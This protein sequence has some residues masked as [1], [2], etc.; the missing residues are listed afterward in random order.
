MKIKNNRIVS[1]TEDELY[2]YW[3]THAWYMIYDFQDYLCRMEDCGVEIV[4]PP[5]LSEGDESGK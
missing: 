5:V 4:R 1:A 3:R 2:E